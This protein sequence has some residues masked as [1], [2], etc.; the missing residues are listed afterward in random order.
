MTDF[1]IYVYADGLVLPLVVPVTC[2]SEN[3]PD[4]LRSLFAHDLVATRAEVWDGSTMIM[5]ID[6]KGIAALVRQSEPTGG[7]QHDRGMIH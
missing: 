1:R 4:R 5:R 7:P 3:L 6:A 2:A